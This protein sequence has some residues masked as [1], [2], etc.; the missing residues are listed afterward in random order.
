MDFYELDLE[1]EVLDGLDAMNFVETS[2]IQSA[3]IP[4]LLEGRDVI[5]CAQTGSGKTAAYLLPFLNKVA[6]RELPADQLGAV[7]MAPTREL[8]KQIDQQVEGFGYYLSVSTLAIYG[9]TDGIAWEQ[10]RRGMAMGADIVIATPGRLLSMLRLGACDLSH[11]RYFVL[12]E[13]DRMLDMGFYEDILEIYKALPKECQHVMFSATMPKEILKLSENILVDPVLV[14][15]AVAKPP[16]SIMQTAYICYD[17]QKLPIIK[18]LFADKEPE[19]V[20]RTIIFAGTKSTVHAL[21][22]TLSR[23]KLS[24]AAMHSDLTQERREEV[25]RDFRMGRIKVLVATDIV[26]RGIDI[27]DIA[28]VVNYEVPH[29]FE[30][31]VHRIGRTARGADGKGLA[32][33]LVSPSD[34]QDFA[35]LERFLEQEIYRIPLDPSLGEAPTYAPN[36]RTNSR[37]SSRGSGGKGRGGRGTHKGGSRGRGGARKGRS[38]GRK[39]AKQ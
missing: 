10:Q 26:A 25:L 37:G 38:G 14:E 5:G 23:D 18:S 24:V 8:A 28:V 9:G 13:A 34:Q 4:P 35:L 32:I 7:V 33:T 12:D 20:P 15:L 39:G 1:D 19:E 36:E 27:D 16:K 17:A 11:V 3:T 31:Y 22:Q 21:S 6:R 29:D 30:D 2:P